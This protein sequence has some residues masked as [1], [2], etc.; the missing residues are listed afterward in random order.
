[1]SYRLEKYGSTLRA[2]LADI[3]VRESLDPGLRRLTVVSVSPTPDLKR[4]TVSVACPA[5][6]EQ[7]TLEGLRGAAGFL[8]KLL[9]R[10]MILRSMPE[11][12][13]E[14]APPLLAPGGPASPG[15]GPAAEGPR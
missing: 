11:L 12:V 4:V 3:L 2:A 5:G 6:E 8:K 7:A 14:I 10:K 13:F 1:M 9:A 15:A